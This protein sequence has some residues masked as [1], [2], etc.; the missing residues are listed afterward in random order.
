LLSVKPIVNVLGSGLTGDISIFLPGFWGNLSVSCYVSVC[1]SEILVSCSA[2]G[3][4]VVGCM[5]PAVQ[6]L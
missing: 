1:S 5:R 6:V 3:H 4:G 2:A